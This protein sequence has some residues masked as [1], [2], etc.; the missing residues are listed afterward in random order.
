MVTYDNGALVCGSGN[1]Y[2]PEYVSDIEV[3]VPLL[4]E[5]ESQ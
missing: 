2:D 1:H 4:L 3:M 5:M